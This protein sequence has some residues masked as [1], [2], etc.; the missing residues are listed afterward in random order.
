ML[1][2]VLSLISTP[3]S[4]YYKYNY[5][6]NKLIQNVFLFIII[7]INVTIFLYRLIKWRV[8]TQ[9]FI[10]YNIKF[11]LLDLR[12]NKYSIHLEITASVGHYDYVF[13]VYSVS[14]CT[15]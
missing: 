9:Y 11:G 4:F 14:S 3:Q 6:T 2:L 8:R 13:R 7:H 5:V 1:I 15:Y 10:I 12:V